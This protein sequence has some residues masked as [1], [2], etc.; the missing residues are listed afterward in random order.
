M[1]HCDSCRLDINTDSKICPLCNSK[2]TGECTPVF[3]VLNTKKKDLLLLIVFIVS[4]IIIAFDMYVDYMNNNKISYS[5]FIFIGVAIFYIL[6][7]Y[8]IK[9]VYKNPLIVFYIFISV[10]D[11]ILYLCLYYTHVLMLRDIIPIM[12]LTNVVLSIFL[13]LSLKKD[14]PRK[15]IYVLLI[16]LFF[17]M[18]SLGLL[19]INK[20]GNSILLH[21]SIWG[22]LGIILGLFLINIKSIKEELIK[23]FYI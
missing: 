16:D 4:L 9:S 20:V 19:I 14:S 23:V 11:V 12:V 1:K 6:L 15:Y 7:R 5:V 10:I 21:S 2:L 13:A 3:P 8:L 18:C 22:T 17:M